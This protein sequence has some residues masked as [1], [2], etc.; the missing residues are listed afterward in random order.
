[1]PLVPV[2]TT[3]LLPASATSEPET[4]ATTLAAAVALLIDTTCTRLLV[5]AALPVPVV[6]GVM[7]SPYE[8]PDEVD[9]R[10]EMAGAA[11][12][13]GLP[14]GTVG[15]VTVILPMSCVP[16]APLRPP[17]IGKPFSS[18]GRLMRVTELSGF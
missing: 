2:P 5:T 4:S 10:A 3:Q 8:F 18:P 7:T 17:F 1:M 11:L 12:S 13:C 14:G 6:T 16:A 15:S 9:A